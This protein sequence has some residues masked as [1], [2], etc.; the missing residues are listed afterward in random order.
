MHVERRTRGRIPADTS[1]V[2]CVAWPPTMMRHDDGCAVCLE[3]A[4]VRGACGARAHAEVV[5]RLRE[6][7]GG[8]VHRAGDVDLD[9][10]RGPLGR[11][12][13]AADG[14]RA[15]RHRQVLALRARQLPPLYQLDDRLHGEVEPHEV[16]EVGAGHEERRLRVLLIHLKLA[17]Q[18]HLARSRD[19]PVAALDVVEVLEGHL[20]GGEVEEGLAGDGGLLVVRHALHR[21]PRQLLLLVQPQPEGV[22]VLR[23]EVPKKR[24]VSLRAVAVALRV[25]GQH[26]G[27]FDW[28][29][30]LRGDLLPHLRAVEGGRRVEERLPECICE[31]IDE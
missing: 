20:R 1:F 4:V 19:L 23:G 11:A 9:V 30:L 8:G 24:G 17:E 7:G 6:R 27:H 29:P 14:P 18:R 21:R 2:H 22:P 15:L 31:A 3:V 5:E 25:G 28:P 12:G 10:L 13:G 16:D 26:E